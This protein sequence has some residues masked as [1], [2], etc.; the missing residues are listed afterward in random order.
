MRTLFFNLLVDELL[1]WVFFRD[2][3]AFTLLNM[4][5]F[6]V[7]GFLLDFLVSLFYLDHSFFFFKGYLVAPAVPSPEFYFDF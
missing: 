5:S 3:F 2:S 1:D 7:I 4:S 6:F